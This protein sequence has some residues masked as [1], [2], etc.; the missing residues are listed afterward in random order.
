MQ[1]SMLARLWFRSA[2]LALVRRWDQC[3][4][5]MALWTNTPDWRTAARACSGVWFAASSRSTPSKPAS[6]AMLNRLARE[7]FLSPSLSE[8]MLSLHDNRSRLPSGGLTMRSTEPPES[9]P[10]ANEDPVEAR[11]SGAEAAEAER[12][13]RRESGE[14]ESFMGSSV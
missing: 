3:A 12:K 11:T 1:C 7:S 5:L 9:A 10:W 14:V 2:S 4:W 13:W 8:I 6:P